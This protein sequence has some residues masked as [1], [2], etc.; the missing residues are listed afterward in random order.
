MLTST[1]LADTATICNVLNVIKEHIVRLGVLFRVKCLVLP[2]ATVYISCY[3]GNGTTP[4]LTSRGWQENRPLKTY[5]D[6]VKEIF[7]DAEIKNGM[8]IA[9][10]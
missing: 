10:N 6:E 8:I 1:R 9:R 5:L 4:T 3:R 2:G 7:P